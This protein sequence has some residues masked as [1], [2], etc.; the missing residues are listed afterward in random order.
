MTISERCTLSNL[1]YIFGPLDRE[2]PTDGIPGCEIPESL[3]IKGRRLPSTI[4]EVRNNLD[5]TFL[6]NGA[7]EGKTAW[8]FIPFIVNQPGTIMF[9]IGAGL[10][11]EAFVDGKP[12][13]DTLG[14]GNKAWP[15]S[16]GNHRREIEMTAGKHLLSVRV[17][18][19]PVEPGLCVAAGTTEDIDSVVALADEARP[20]SL[21]TIV[22]F[23]VPNGTVKPLHGVNNGPVTNGSLMDVSEN[24]RELAIPWVRIHDSNCPHPREVDIPQIF[25][26]ENADPENP[27]NYDFSR[28]DTYLKS[29]LDIGA[30]IVYRLGTS[31]EHTPVK[32][33]IYP[34]KDFTRWAKVCIGIIK[35]YNHGWANG[36]NYGISHWEIWNEPEGP[37]MWL[38]TEEQ[39]LEL[40]AVASTMI[41]KFDHTIKIGGFA[42][43]DPRGSMV[44]H[45]LEYC[46]KHDLPLDFFSWHSYA[47]MPSTI[48]S[49]AIMI[50]SLLDRYGFKTTESHLNE[51]NLWPDWE[52][53]RL[54]RSDQAHYR[55]D[56]F[57]RQKNEVGA[58]FS[59][60]TLIR[61]Q[62][63]KVDVANYF[64]GQPH[65]YYCGLF[66]LYGV[67]QKTYTAF[68]AFRTLLDYPERVQTQS[69]DDCV[70]S[71]AVID[72]NRN[73]ATILLAKYGGK[74]S[75]DHH[76]LLKNLPLKFD[77]Y[78][79]Q[80]IDRDHQGEIIKSEK[81]GVE[82]KI[83]IPLREYAVAKI[84]LMA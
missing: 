80:M 68:H 65:N 67:P 11:F 16:C 70:D 35:H 61:L 17:I 69:K 54:S 81:I 77:R 40:Y 47:H 20:N 38:G 23:A 15:P 49:N 41:K 2:D 5:L 78:E 6:L 4:M 10:W 1:W 30:K 8:V 3:V 25:P 31:I 64:D 28:T 12:L 9:G 53:N 62:D 21:T 45:F 24:Y 63:A 43:A 27:A 51:W 59:V 48:E 79:L 37:Q 13:M 66:D 82:K 72:S 36:F 60:S 83:V 71:L 39:Y 55:R 75:I 46:R 57:E 26:D 52:M 29:I 32:Y 56:R 42:S 7:Q 18:S 50:R 19:G 44:L 76:I 74:A 22:D 14:T 58:S 34:P 84:V 33:Y 73:R